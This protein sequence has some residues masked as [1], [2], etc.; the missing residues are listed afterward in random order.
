[1]EKRQLITLIFNNY[2]TGVLID[3][4]AHWMFIF[5]PCLKI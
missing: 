3:P 5:S 1:M 2:F 4:L